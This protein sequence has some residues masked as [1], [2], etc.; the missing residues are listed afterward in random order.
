MMSAAERQRRYVERHPERLR[1]RWKAYGDK[2]KKRKAVNAAARYARDKARILEA[3][4]A[5]RA[6]NPEKVFLLSK[7]WREAN[8]EKRRQLHKQWR[9]ANPDKI[10][11]WRAGQRAKR[12]AAVVSLTPHEQAEVIALYAKARALTELIGEPYHVD[13]IKPL[14]KGGLHH[15]NN[16]QVLKGAENLRKGAKY[17]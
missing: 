15:P 2:N 16:L 4:R 12:K 6:S 8:P 1:A 10:M 14:A 5:W 11:A 13:H 3:G 7:K 9:D 17:G